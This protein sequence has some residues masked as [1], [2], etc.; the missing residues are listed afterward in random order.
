MVLELN[1]SVSLPEEERFARF[2][3]KELRDFLED[4]RSKYD[5]VVGSISLGSSSRDKVVSVRIDEFSALLFRKGTDGDFDLAGDMIEALDGVLDA[6][7]LGGIDLYIRVGDESFAIK[8]A[9]L[10]KRRASKSFVVDG[11]IIKNT[12]ERKVIRDLTDQGIIKPPMKVLMVSAVDRWGM[13]ETFWNLGYRCM[14]GDLIFSF[15]LNRPVTSLEELERFGRYLLKYITKLPFELLYP[16]GKKQKE[17]KPYEGP[18]KAYYEVADIIA[19]DFHYVI[20]YM[21]SNMSGKVV[22]TNTLT[23]RDVE[24]LR[25]RGVRKL[26][27]TTPRLGGRS[28]GTNLVEALLS[29]LTFKRWGYFP[30]TEGDFEKA[31]DEFGLTYTL[32]F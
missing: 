23:Q 27:T 4:Q 3:L 25:R 10:L 13:A 1:T 26:I 29:A 21:P 24:D 22:I 6:I 28:F 7:G 17:R 15:G 20:K 8:D 2:S 18:F 32:V 12:L 14:F 5:I 16:V 19:G 30:L 9:L 31:I 11:S